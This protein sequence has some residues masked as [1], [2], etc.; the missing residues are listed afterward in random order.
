MFHVFSVTHVCTEDIYIV[1]GVK[2]KLLGSSNT[3][4]DLALIFGE[5]TSHAKVS[6]LRRPLVIKQDVTG[7]YVTMDDAMM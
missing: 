6:D 7:L 5:E 1:E 3:C 2:L 4:I